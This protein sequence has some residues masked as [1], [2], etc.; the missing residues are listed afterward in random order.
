[1]SATFGWTMSRTKE[2]L[3]NPCGSSI[4]TG[5][6]SWIDGKNDPIRPPIVVTTNMN[7]SS[8]PTRPDGSSRSLML[9]T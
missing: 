6:V 2:L 8:L 1:M 7:P 3:V 9:P 4:S 5:E